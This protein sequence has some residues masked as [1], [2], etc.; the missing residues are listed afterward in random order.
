MTTP[1]LRLPCAK[2]Q[3]GQ[4][5]IQH[6]QIKNQNHQMII[7]VTADDFVFAFQRALSP[8]T[9]SPTCSSMFCIKN[10]KE[11]N[12]GALPTNQLGVTAK[13]AHTLVVQLAY[14]YENFP[15]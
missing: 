10:A 1:F 5:Q 14:S 13:D 7:P 11:V 9:K 12:S 3:N 4:I 15:R 2:M 6:R 8:A